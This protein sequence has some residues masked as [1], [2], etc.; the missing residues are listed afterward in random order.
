VAL[1]QEAGH[2]RN[3]WQGHGGAVSSREASDRHLKLKDLLGRVRRAFGTAWDRFEAVIPGPSRFADG[4]FAYTLR[5]AVGKAFP[6]AETEAL[7][8]D[9]ME[10]GYLHFLGT[11]ETRALKVL[12]FVRFGR[13][14]EA[15]QSACYFYNRRQKGQ[16]RFVSYHFE[17]EAELIETD[18][19]T[20]RLVAD[21][22]G[23]DS[24]PGT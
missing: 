3:L 15:A 2:F 23:N 21:F 22:S 18:S 10:D 4:R 12:P 6:F 11:G 19:E 24:R 16:I 14:P 13:S 9:P 7:L 8:T 20:E 17:D 5:R 1:L